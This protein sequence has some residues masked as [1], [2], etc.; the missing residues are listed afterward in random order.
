MGHHVWPPEAET[1]VGEQC[2]LVFP[3][4]HIDSEPTIAQNWPLSFER[5]GFLGC[6]TSVINISSSQR[7]WCTILFP[8]KKKKCTL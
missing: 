6:C 4:V 5:L 7:V 1:A 8:K 2:I 3:S